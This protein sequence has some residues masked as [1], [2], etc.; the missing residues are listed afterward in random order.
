MD[1]QQTLKNDELDTL[2]VID[3]MRRCRQ[4]KSK[5]GLEFGETLDELERLYAAGK[6]RDARIAELM[7][8]VNG[9]KLTL[10]S[11]SY[12]LGF[13]GFR[14][15]MHE[16]TAGELASHSVIIEEAPPEATNG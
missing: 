7:R 2:S 8:E 15:R 5:R 12:Q 3:L 1:S 6:R 16:N 11:I 4:V 9:L 14:V 10:A 13:V